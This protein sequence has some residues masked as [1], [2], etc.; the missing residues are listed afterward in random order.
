[1]DPLKFKA[2]PLKTLRGSALAAFKAHKANIDAI[3]QRQAMSQAQA[4]AKI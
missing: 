4:A 2:Q 1:V 3:V